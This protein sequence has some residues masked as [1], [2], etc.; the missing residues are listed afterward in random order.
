MLSEGDGLTSLL[1]AGRPITFDM[2]KHTDNQVIWWGAPREIT[3]LSSVQIECNQMTGGEHT[4]QP[5]ALEQQEWRSRF[6]SHKISFVNS[7]TGVY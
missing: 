6:M 2:D 3:E 1:A 4:G 7:C 5:V